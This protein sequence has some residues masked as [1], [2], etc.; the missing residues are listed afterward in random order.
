MDW[1]LQ[2]PEYGYYMSR[3]DISDSGDFITSPELYTGFGES[4][5]IWVVFTWQQMVKPKTF[6]LFELGPGTGQLMSDILKVCTIPEFSAMK[7][8]MR[9]H[10]IES[11]PKMRKQQA[12]KLGIDDIIEKTVE[13]PKMGVKK[14]DYQNLKPEELLVTDRRDLREAFLKLRQQQG[15]EEGEDVGEDPALNQGA[16]RDAFVDQFNTLREK[17]RAT[18]SPEE[19]EKM[20]T[21]D[22]MAGKFDAEWDNLFNSLSMETNMVGRNTWKGITPQG[23]TVNWHE[24]MD[25]IPQGPT[26]VVAN[27]FFDALPMQRFQ[28][29]G[30]TEG[31]REWLVDI[32]VDPDHVAHLAVKLANQKTQG[33][34]L[35]EGHY[36]RQQASNPE[37]GTNMEFSPASNLIM[38]ELAE[39]VSKHGGAGVIIDYGIEGPPEDSLQAVRRH[40]FVDPFVECGDSDITAYVDFSA[41]AHS[42]REHEKVRVYGPVTQ[43]YFLQGCGIVER[44]E[45]IIEGLDS[46]EEREEM[47][48][49]FK[50]VVG[51]EEMGGFF[52][53][54]GFAHTSIGTPIGFLEP[55]KSDDY[56]IAFDTKT[57]R[58]LSTKKMQKLLK[59]QEEEAK[60]KSDA[61]SA[62]LENVDMTAVS[63]YSVSSSYSNLDEWKDF[64]LTP[65]EDAWFSKKGAKEWVIFDLGQLCLVNTLEIRCGKGMKFHMPRDMVLQS[66]HL[67]D[68]DELKWDKVRTAHIQEPQDGEWYSFKVDKN[69]RWFRIILHQTAGKDNFALTQVRFV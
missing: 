55:T 46:Q 38:S 16:N 45:Q 3:V 33:S 64:I 31:W 26:I 30:P 1:C 24:S 50:R 34:D 63:V 23:V 37:P 59:D 4:I 13:I 68:M 32:D 21:A 44:A 11:S 61:G 28:Y 56:E 19:F 53:A 22:Q 20:P 10:M 25:T 57:G 51:I 7:R 66:T 58:K 49:S 29:T 12:E 40:R 6:H 48:K 36:R 5:G 65:N 2:H 47:L 39:R 42:I 14:V 9:V 18:I 52:K 60:L 41:L 62:I 67:E 35:I 43:S 27:E 69:A 54:L 8:S 17:A 15:K